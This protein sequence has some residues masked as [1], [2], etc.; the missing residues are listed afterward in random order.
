MYSDLYVQFYERAK[1]TGGAV[2]LECDN[3]AYHTHEKHGA[4]VAVYYKQSAE[5]TFCLPGLPRG[6]VHK[7]TAYVVADKGTVYVERELTDGDWVLFPT[8][9]CYDKFKWTV[10]AGAGPWHGFLSYEKFSEKYQMKHTR[11]SRDRVITI[12]SETQTTMDSGGVT[13]EM[14]DR[15]WET[16][17]PVSMLIAVLKTIPGVVR[18]K[19]DTYSHLGYQKFQLKGDPRPWPSVDGRL[20]SNVLEYIDSNEG[21]NLVSTY[22]ENLLLIEGLAFSGYLTKRTLKGL[23]VRAWSQHRGGVEYPKLQLAPEWLP[24]A[25]RE[26][27]KHQL[28]GYEDEP[29]FIETMTLDEGEFGFELT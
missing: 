8:T 1:V 10:I 5:G 18:L 22:D 29:D 28:N 23:Y 12:M 21:A 20:V 3:K 4:D 7:R 27:R 17:Q 19:D 15:E 14:M 9:A 26:A 6:I 16:P 13:F 2:E 25:E 24:A 11:N